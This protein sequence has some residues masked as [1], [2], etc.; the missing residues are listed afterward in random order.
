[1]PYATSSLPAPPRRATFA[2]E[3]LCGADEYRDA[4]LRDLHVCLDRPVL[5]TLENVVCLPTDGRQMARFASAGQMSHYVP[6]SDKPESK[7]VAV[8]R[9][10]T[11]VE[12]RVTAPA[13]KERLVGS[14]LVTLKSLL[15]AVPAI[16]GLM[17]LA[18]HSVAWSWHGTVRPIRCGV[19]GNKRRAQRAEG[20]IPCCWWPAWFGATPAAQLRSQPSLPIAGEEKEVR[21]AA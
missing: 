21:R 20:S 12:H 14:P 17:I 7:P 15:I 18:T 19:G 13:V 1:M 6:R 16:V 10:D 2:S 3:M 4:V 5:N 9:Q 11:L 8:I